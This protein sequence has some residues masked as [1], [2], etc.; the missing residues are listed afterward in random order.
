MKKSVLVRN[1]QH[2]RPM[3]AVCH[4]YG[5]G[6]DDKYGRGVWITISD[7][8]TIADKME[9]DPTAIRGK[10]NGVPYLMVNGTNIHN[11]VMM[12]DFEELFTDN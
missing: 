9:T 6:A 12:C 4:R 10:W 3:L 8:Q 2:M 7:L 5:V 11:Q 1:G